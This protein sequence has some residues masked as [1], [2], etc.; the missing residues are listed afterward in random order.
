M[1][2]MRWQET[3]PAEADNVDVGPLTEADLQ[4]DLLTTSD[5][6]F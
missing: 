1:A 6:P 3:Q 2:E 5:D 4:G